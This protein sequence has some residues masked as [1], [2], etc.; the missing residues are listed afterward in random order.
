M[1]EGGG[2]GCVMIL[3]YVTA[4]K[5]KLA[6][7]WLLLLTGIL[8]HFPDMGSSDACRLWFSGIL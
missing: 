3:H 8:F 4:F 1:Q 5:I 6:L 7:V 2:G